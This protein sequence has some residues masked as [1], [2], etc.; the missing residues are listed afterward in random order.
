MTM[1]LVAPKMAAEVPE[2]DEWIGSDT[3]ADAEIADVWIL[4]VYQHS[5]PLCLY[6]EF[7]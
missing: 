3:K 5:L 4:G 2:R 7:E 1:N 6:F